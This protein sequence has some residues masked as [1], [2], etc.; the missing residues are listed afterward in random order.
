MSPRISSRSADRRRF[1]GHQLEDEGADLGLGAL[2]IHRRQRLEIEAVEQLAV[3]VGLQL[4]VLGPDV[5]RS[6]HDGRFGPRPGRRGSV[7]SVLGSVSGRGHDYLVS[8]SES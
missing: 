7:R 6:E 4:D 8:S 1:L 5:R 3:D 2:S